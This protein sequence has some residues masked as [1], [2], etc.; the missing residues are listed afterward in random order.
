[1]HH[2]EFP[3]D[4]VFSLISFGMKTLVCK[5]PGHFS[6][7]E[8]D[9]PVP[10]KGFSVIKIK[11]VGICGTD[12]HAFEG[13]QPFFSYPRVLGHELAAEFE[14]GDAPGFQKGD[15]LTVIP[16]IHCGSC[17]ACRQGKTNCCSS[18][19]VLGVHVDGGMSEYFLA[20]NELLLK[21]D[22]LPIDALALV[23]P[24]C[25]GYHAV[26]RS[27]IQP[28][29]S[30]LVIGAGPIGFGLMLF[31]KAKGVKV[32]GMDINHDRLEFCHTHLQ[33]DGMV[34]PKDEDHFDKIKVLTSGEMPAVVFDA[35]GNGKAINN[36]FR[37][38]SH[39]GKY[40]L[41]GLQLGDISFSHPEF[42]KREA[43]LMSSRNATQHDF[44][45]VMD[46]I[47]Q[48]KIDP[49]CM[50]THRL[51]FDEVEKSFDQLMD[52]AQQVVKAMVSC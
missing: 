13:T 51:R 49:L 34:D 48:K 39:A 37:Y 16:Y 23:E 7:Q 21:G 40:V 31:L 47:R 29:E 36:A 10:K 45:E 12:L 25:I 6:Y 22:G 2:G 8:T 17:I 9:H 20:P 24:L 18:L 15:P 1:M 11:R 42:H 35:T 52:P 44:L 30:A 5:N 4:A 50:I 43:T 19:K 3:M 38:L 46:M 33:M 26:Q 41:V 28:S 32:V 14:E 27:A